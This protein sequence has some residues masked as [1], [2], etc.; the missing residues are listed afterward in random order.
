M[1]D[2]VPFIAPTVIFFFATD[3]KETGCT[4]GTMTLIDAHHGLVT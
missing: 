4:H 1:C 3:P 2:V